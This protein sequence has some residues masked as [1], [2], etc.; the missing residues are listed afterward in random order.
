MIGRFTDTCSA[1]AGNWPLIVR[2]VAMLAGAYVQG[3]WFGE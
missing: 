1:S 3:G 2:V